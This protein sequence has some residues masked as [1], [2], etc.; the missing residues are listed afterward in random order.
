MR[1]I[2]GIREASFRFSSGRN[3]YAKPL[4]FAKMTEGRTELT[5]RRL[6]SSASSQR[7]MERSMKSSEKHSWHHRMPIAIG[8]SKL[9]H[10]FLMSAG[11]RLIVMRVAGKLNQEFR[12]A[13]RTLSLLSW[14]AMSASQTMLKFGIQLLISTSTSIRCPSSQLMATENTLVSI[15]SL[16]S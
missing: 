5:G 3:T 11:A 1:E 7:K 2:S 15:D 8:R 12:M 10:R 13:V 16:L 6:P 9:G 14:M 4:S